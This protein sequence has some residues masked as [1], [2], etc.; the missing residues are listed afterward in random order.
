MQAE[1]TEL[2][3]KYQDNESTLLLPDYDK[4]SGLFL[5]LISQCKVIFNMIYLQ[6]I[7]TNICLYNWL[8]GKSTLLWIIEKIFV[9]FV[10]FFYLIFSQSMYLA[11]S[12]D[13]WVM[14]MKQRFSEQ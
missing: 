1:N 14:D 10:K 9:I 11:S 7:Q 5:K 12:E 6:T 2:P 13:F 8:F 4:T 3:K